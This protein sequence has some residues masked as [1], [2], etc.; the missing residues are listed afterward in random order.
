MIRPT[1]SILLLSTPSL[2]FLLANMFADVVAAADVVF[3]LV[4]VV[5]AVVDVFVVVVVAVADDLD[6]R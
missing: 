3:L 1:Q 2:L 4:V 5:A 6:V